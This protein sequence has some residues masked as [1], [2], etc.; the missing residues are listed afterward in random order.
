MTCHCRLYFVH[1]NIFWMIFQ[2]TRW[3]LQCSHMGSF[4]ELALRALWLAQRFVP[5][6]TN[7]LSFTLHFQ[8]INC[9]QQGKFTCLWAKEVICQSIISGCDFS[10]QLSVSQWATKLMEGSWT[11]LSSRCRAG[12]KDIK[13]LK[14]MDT[15]N[16]G[17]LEN[18]SVNHSFI[19]IERENHSQMRQCIYYNWDKASTCSTHTHKYDLHIYVAEVICILPRKML[20]KLY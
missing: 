18:H 11:L 6:A 5:K 13:Q 2:K 4:H 7:I 16:T 10:F 14:I 15:R 17:L 9:K 1:V 20:T 3:C 12:D 19:S 8:F